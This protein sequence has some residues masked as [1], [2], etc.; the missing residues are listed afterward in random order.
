MP[1]HEIP[2]VPSQRSARPDQIRAYDNRDDRLELANLLKHLSPLRRVQFLQWVCAL[3]VLP[4]SGIHPQPTRA[5]WQL[6]EQARHCDAADERLTLSVLMDLVH[7]SIDYCVDLP[8]VVDELVRW[9]RRPHR[10]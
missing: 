5:M 9:A 7:M 3:A 10:P 2:L 1:V 8:L 4:H 6:A